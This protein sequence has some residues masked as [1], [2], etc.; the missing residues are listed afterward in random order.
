MQ[1]NVHFAVISKWRVIFFGELFL[2]TTHFFFSN[3]LIE[4]F[5]F[6][7]NFSNLGEE[8]EALNFVPSQKGKF[9]LTHEGYYY[10]RE[11]IVN[12]KVYWRCIE[13]TS[14][15]RCHARIHTIGNSIVRNTP[16]CHPP[17]RSKK[18]TFVIFEGM[19]DE[20]WGKD[21]EIHLKNFL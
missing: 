5:F 3:L 7:I 17:I 12:N 20:F 4:H 8:E 9:Q 19:K 21:E 14:K 18:K 11:K 16:H 1:T 10:V 15:I 6:W 2:T 13:Y